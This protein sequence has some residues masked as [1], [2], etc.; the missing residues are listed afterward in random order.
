M[1]SQ[2]IVKMMQNGKNIYEAGKF[3]VETTAY[4]NNLTLNEELK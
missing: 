3:S 4:I 2:D 1:N